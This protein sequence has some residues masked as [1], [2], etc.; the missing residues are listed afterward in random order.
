MSFHY[1]LQDWLRDWG[2]MAEAS[3]SVP[4]EK[5]VNW[6]TDYYRSRYTDSSEADWKLDRMLRAIRYTE[7]HFDSFESESWLFGS[8][9]NMVVG[10][11]LV[12]A[13]FRFF[14]HATDVQVNNEPPPEIIMRAAQECRE[15]RGKD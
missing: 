9:Q 5:S 1:T 7:K 8:Q 15:A 12:L 3:E 14:S 2:A 6:A 13:L 4:R 10:K 11:D